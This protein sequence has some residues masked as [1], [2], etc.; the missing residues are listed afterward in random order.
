MA[1]KK[2]QVAEN[3]IT[4]VHILTVPLSLR[5]LRGQVGYM[6]AR[7][8][9]VDVLSSPGPLLDEFAQQEQ[10]TAHSVP[11]SR[12][13]SPLRDLVAVWDIWRKLHRIRPAIVH[14]HTPKGGLLGMIGAWLARVKVRIYHIHGLRYVTTTGSQRWLLRASE[15]LSCR[16]AHQVF[17]VSSSVREVVISEGLCPAHKIKVIHNGSINGVDAVN[18]FNPLLYEQERPANRSQHSIPKDALVIGYLGRIVKD[19]G[20]TELQEAWQSLRYDYPNLHLLL[21][22]P[23][24]PQDP[25][26]ADVEAALRRDERVHIV[27]KTIDYEDIPAYYCAMDVVAFPTYRE[28]FGM[29][30][31]EGAAMG[32]P[33]VA[34]RIPGCVDAVVDGVT[35]TLVPVRDSAAL[36]QA[37]RAYL[38]DP[39]LRTAHGEAGRARVL[40][41]FRPED[42]WEAI[43][44]HYVALLRA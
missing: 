17:C 20:I 8:F 12:S 38:D 28:G 32:L 24:E 27:D 34:T 37:I 39:A 29:I 23:F 42:I 3:P 43:H 4:L 19:K 15:W 25:L 33:V 2:E 30:G 21:A 6:K 36:A 9:R 1:N 16:L 7:G 14:A 31:I 10:V 18:L 44:A 26:P 35:G 5:F 22:G 11:M 40:R 13:I 41:D